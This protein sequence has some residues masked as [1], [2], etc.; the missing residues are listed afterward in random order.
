[1]TSVGPDQTL[2]AE[3]SDVGDARHHFLARGSIVG[4]YI[5]LSQVGA[6]GMGVVYAA[7]DPDL[8]RKVAL[9]LLQ[10]DIAHSANTMNDK[11]LLREAQAL[12]RLSHPNVV[13]VHDVGEL[14]GSIWIAMEFVDGQTFSEWLK[15]SSRDW[16]L[17]LQ[18]LQHIG[19]GVA[20][21]HAIG[22]V[23]RDLK[24]DNIMIG[25][26]RRVRVMD[27]GL[28]RRRQIMEPDFAVADTAARDSRAQPA[29]AALALQMTQVGAV[30]GTPAYMALEQFRGKEVDTPADIFSF[31]AIAWEALYGTPAF[32]GA[33]LIE[34]VASLLSGKVRPPPA[35]AKVPSWLRRVL[36]SGLRPDPE[37]R[38][39]SMA[40]LLKALERG[41]QGARAWKLAFAASCIVAA[42]TLALKRESDQADVAATRRAKCEMNAGSD[43]G[44]VWNEARRAEA[45]RAMLATGLPYAADTWTRARGRLD[46]YVSKWNEVY[47]ETC[48]AGDVVGTLS[49]AVYQ[50]RLACLER[51]RVEFDALTGT[52]AT[53][54][55]KVVEQ[56]VKASVLLPGP[57][58]CTERDT[59]AEEYTGD[60][61][62]AGELENLRQALARARAHAATGRYTTAGEEANDIVEH[63]R[64]LGDL[65]VQA[66]AL[67]RRGV[68]EENAGNYKA[69]EATL[70]DAY[71]LAEQA[72]LDAL[73]A[74]IAASLV[75]VVGTRLARFS[76]GEAW[77]RQ[78][79]SINT[80][81][82]LGGEPRA[83]LLSLQSGMRFMQGKTDLGIRVSQDALDLQ[84]QLYGVD[85]V[86]VAIAHLNLGGGL[87]N[88][89]AYAEAEAH[90]RRS[91]QIFEEQLGATHPDLAPT[92][93]N[94]ATIAEKMGRL[95]D[96]VRLCARAI[97]VRE[98]SFGPNHPGIAISLTNLGVFQA[99]SGDVAG[100]ESSYRRAAQIF[101]VANGM[102]HPFLGSALSGLS[103]VLIEQR[104]FDEARVVNRRVHEILSTVPSLTSYAQVDLAKLELA[105]GNSDAAVQPATRAYE[106]RRDAKAEDQGEAA[107]LLSRALWSSAKEKIRSRA[108]AEEAVSAYRT[109]G[110]GFSRE[111]AE[112]E[113]WRRQIE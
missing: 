33:T 101:E 100:A 55:A 14:D 13:T 71:H 85:D 72:G 53:A 113:A 19:Q 60:P 21:A 25:A 77:L 76:D 68:W 78:A 51:Q 58:R 102:D 46:T 38:W 83:R 63:A 6:G 12:A 15:Q 26:D 79:D 90:E 10:P 44:T 109:T 47:T 64:A 2:A 110:V 57:M 106:L 52:L 98:L 104:R 93:N 112:A 50:R 45:E 94:L 84:K 9:K 28:A 61:M 87:F 42:I 75:G 35:N 67:G 22:L 49:P 41:P 108:L 92:L 82:G 69:A 107:L 32:T 30:I 8:D 1:M 103:R 5:V 62:L 18:V 4:R 17:T 54:D 16:R 97:A 91:L 89:G 24:P 7:Y 36:E 37:Q 39:S 40:V 48:L 96:A 56:A 73:R 59:G 88:R 80:R 70:I 81:L 111:L 20:A 66:E 23:H 74:E 31:C 105:A 65:G 3:T 99:R 95:D 86:R 34:R 43:I 29:L 27:F 11:R